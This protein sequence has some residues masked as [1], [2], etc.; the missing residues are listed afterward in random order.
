MP[1][2]TS[3]PEAWV[4]DGRERVC[5]RA[6]ATFLPLTAETASDAIGMTVSG[7]DRELLRDS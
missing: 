5:A 4:L 7:T 2:T 1:A 6:Q 3:P